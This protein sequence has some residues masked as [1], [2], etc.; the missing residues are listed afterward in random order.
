MAPL[1]FRL[2]GGRDAVLAND[3]TTAIG[4]TAKTVKEETEAGRSATR[5]S[6]ICRAGRYRV[7]WFGLK[8]PHFGIRRGI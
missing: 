4:F 7:A 1:G 8:A 6:G 5:V 3:E 2:G